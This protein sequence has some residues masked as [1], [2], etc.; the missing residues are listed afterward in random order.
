V[1]TCSDCKL[2]KPLSA[3]YLTSNVTKGGVARHLKRC[4]PCHRT[5]RAEHEGEGK[6]PTMKVGVIRHPDG[7]LEMVRKV[8]S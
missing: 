4:K 1:K 3:F 6:A 8:A 7:S 5:H 2:P